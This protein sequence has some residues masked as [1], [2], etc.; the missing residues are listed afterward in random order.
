MKEQPE[1]IG[2]VKVVQKIKYIGIEI[3]NK[4]YL[5]SQRDKIIQ[6]A[7]NMTN[8]TYSVIEKSYTKL[9]IGKTFWD[10]IVLPS[11]LYG[12]NIIHLIE[13]NINELQK[14]ENNVVVVVVVVYPLP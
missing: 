6:K 10:S 4:N 5:K 1:Y 3:E 12:T 11:V 8:I 9:L 14:I 7:W 2:N 13:D